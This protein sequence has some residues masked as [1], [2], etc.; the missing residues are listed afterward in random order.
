MGVIGFSQFDFTP[1]RFA[2]KFFLRKLLI[3]N[4]LLIQYHSHIIAAED[5]PHTWILNHWNCPPSSWLFGGNWFVHTQNWK[6]FVNVGSASPLVLYR[7]C[8]N[9]RRRLLLTPTPVSLMLHCWAMFC[10]QLVGAECA[11]SFKRWTANIDSSATAYVGSVF[12]H[13]SFCSATYEDQFDSFLLDLSSYQYQ[14]TV[15]HFDGLGSSWLRFVFTRLL[16]LELQVIIWFIPSK[17]NIATMTSVTSSTSMLRLTNIMMHLYTI[18]NQDSQ[19]V[20][21]VA[22][23]LLLLLLLLLPPPAGQRSTGCCWG[24][25]IVVGRVQVDATMLEELS[26]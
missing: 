24:Q 12:A 3:D 18:T 1:F 6:T 25:A 10:S 14:W 21:F 13:W 20:G 16:S 9:R 15:W 23:L 19:Y 2:D 7:Q 11:G 4:V 8:F 22:L 5:N 26:V 17:L